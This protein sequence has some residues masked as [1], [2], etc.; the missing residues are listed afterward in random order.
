[1]KR[2]TRKKVGMGSKPKDFKQFDVVKV[3]KNNK[4]T[5]SFEM[6]VLF[7]RKLGSYLRSS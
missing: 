5:G 7:S 3:Y 2:Y 1:M 6:G 4:H